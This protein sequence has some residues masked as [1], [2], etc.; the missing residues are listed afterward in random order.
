MKIL[1]V[2]GAVALSCLLLG[3]AL[4]APSVLTPAPN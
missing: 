1:G 3:Q 4:S 2:M